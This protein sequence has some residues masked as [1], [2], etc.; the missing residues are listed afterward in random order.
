MWEKSN[1]M[2][3]TVIT[4]IIKN[5]NFLPILL[6]FL[7]I[8]SFLIL[9]KVKYFLYTFF[10]IFAIIGILFYLFFKKKLREENLE[11]IIKISKEKSRLLKYVLNISYFTF[12]G[13]SI[14]SLINSFYNKSIY[15]YLFISLCVGINAIDIIIV[16]KPKDKYVNLI[17]SLLIGLNLFLSSQIIF[18]DGIGS[19][20]S[21]GNIFAENRPSVYSIAHSGHVPMGNTYT[22]FPL[23]FIFTAINCLVTGIN[24]A[25]MYYYLGALL[26]LSGS[27]I[28]FILGEKYINPTFGLLAALIYPSMDY[29]LFFGAHAHQVSFSIPL[30]LFL[31]AV[32]LFEI[33]YRN[34]I[35]LGFFLLFSITLIFTHHLSSFY[36]L[37]ILISYAIFEIL[38]KFK[39]EIKKYTFSKLFLVYSL[40]VFAHWSY[41]TNLLG[42]FAKTI[43]EYLN[44]ASLEK[45]YTVT[46]YDKLSIDTIFLNTFGSSILIMLSI[47]G[48]FL[49][50]CNLSSFKKTIVMIV[51]TLISLIGID[52]FIPNHPLMPQRLYAY[53]EALGLIFL[54]SY[55]LYFLLKNREIKLKIASVIII[56]VFVF[57]STSSF[58]AGFETSPFLGEQGFVRTF[59]T[60]QEKQINFWTDTYTTQ[61]TATISFDNDDIKIDG[62]IDSYYI[63]N[64]LN[65][66]S[67][68][69]SKRVSSTRFQ[70]FSFSHPNPNNIY[71]I[72]NKN[73]KNYDSGILNIYTFN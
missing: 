9:I 5:E 6:L 36:F 30:I 12:F 21:N 8:I 48:F 13:L 46:F 35:F 33:S 73:D 72:L 37:T 27:I 54:S 14:I 3:K 34:K 18:P 32:I 39:G 64:E 52:I 56:T 19:I 70:G 20:D 57:F 61:N 59:T 28:V 49:F 7:T 29:V 10:V 15:Y 41:T 63:L 42:T 26:V 69:E 50:L 17:K 47:I 11:Y 68:F 16:K 22:Y 1:L 51:V 23:H 55:C 71:S 44:A 4:K 62:I 65:F 45:S 60:T 38:L 43:E 2:K 67:G 25:T 40:C 53:L 66:I 58:I 24:Y 31:L